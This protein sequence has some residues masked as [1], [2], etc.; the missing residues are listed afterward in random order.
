MLVEFRPFRPVIEIWAMHRDFHFL[1]TA[2][3][4]GIAKAWHCVSTRELVRMMA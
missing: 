3:A 4:R 2:T 1:T